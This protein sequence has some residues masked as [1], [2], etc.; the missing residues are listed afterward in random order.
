MAEIQKLYIGVM[1]GTSLDGIDCVLVNFNGQ[2]MQLIASLHTAYPKALRDKLIQLC[3]SFTVNVKDLGC[4]H[5]EL[6]ELYSKA[7]MA[8]LNNTKISAKKVI[9]IGNHGQTIYHL[10]EGK[11]PF[12]MQIGNAAVIAARTGIDV[13]ADFRSIDMA[14]GGQGAPLVPAFHAAV[15]AKKNKN[16]AVVNI[17]GMS[18]VTL[19]PASGKVSGFDTGPGNVLMDLWIQAHK[20]QAY[21][22]NGSWAKSGQ[23]HPQLLTALL[24]EAFF[25]QKPPKS[26][27]RELFNTEWLKS[28]LVKFKNLAA[29]DVQATLLELTAQSITM[30]L[31]LARFK[32]DGLFI[33]GGGAY[34]QALLQ[35]IK[36]LNPGTYVDTTNK[37][38]IEPSWV[39]AMA[40]AWL[41]K[42]TVEGKPGNLPSVTGAKQACVLGAKYYS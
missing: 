39:E 28:K 40:F 13:I 25:K 7:I 17:G 34:N 33:C 38:G 5:T 16:V 21:D 20:R 30:A 19:I 8:L 14:F 41:A 42:Q 23:V 37:L 1:S 26:T 35:R 2:K 31:K 10:P 11:F 3:Q 27:G 6:G 32:A 9:A 15:F 18:N 29:E 36:T 4:L 22:K 12:T 24:A